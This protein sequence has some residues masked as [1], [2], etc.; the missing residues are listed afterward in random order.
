[1]FVLAP[2]LLVVAAGAAASDPAEGMVYIRVFGDVQVEFTRP[3]KQKVAEEGVLI[4]TGSG[5]VI[6]PSGLILTSNHVVSGET[7]VGRV[8]GDEARLTTIVKRIEV[9]VGSGGSRQTF[10]PFVAAADPGL[11]LAVLQ[12]SVADLPFIPFGDSDAAEPGR[13][14]RV[15]GFPYGSRVEVGRALGSDVVPE[16]TVTAGSVS[17]ARADEEGQTQ[18][19][20]TDAS[21]HPGSSG[22]PMLDEDGYALGLVKMKI[23][24]GRGGSGPGFTVPIN[25]VKDFLDA[26]GLLQQL[27][28]ARLR[29]GVVQGLGWKGL[30][31]ELPD[32]FSDTSPARLRLDTS[33]SEPPFS[34]VVQRVAT[35]WTVAALEEVLLKG[36]I[37]GLLPASAEPVRHVERGRPPRVV[38]SAGGT[39]ADGRPFRVEYAVVELGREKVVARYVAPPDDMAFNL[40]VVR[41]S[42]EGLEATRLLTDEVRAPLKV[43]FEP[44]QYPGAAFGTVLL[45]AGWAT[46]PASPLSCE[47]IGAAETGLAASPMG[48]F[49]VVF[50]ALRWAPSAIAPLELARAC[51]AT[52]GGTVFSRRSERLGVVVDTVGAIVTRGGEVL[53]LEAEAPETKLSFVRDAFERWVQK[54]AAGAAD[55]R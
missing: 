50:R 18:Y 45:P 9:V 48:D 31:I 38:G 30:G 17:A 2:I 55:P 23:A 33:D 20:Q 42:L 53:L 40:S 4:A 25:Q 5:F 3:W 13:A 19:L 44:V 28:T 8:Q 51:G 22:G 6:A 39:T 54:I 36:A 49:T 15:L 32:G 12:A 14:T 43:T 1:M 21:V 34:V 29:G 7:K 47:R 27:P 37:P 41:R 46:E 52:P 24:E 11:D 10:E 35:P 16:V 26:H